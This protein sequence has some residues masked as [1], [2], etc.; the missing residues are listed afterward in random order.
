MKKAF[1][2]IE[3]VFV[4]VVIGVL[5]AVILPNTKT[6]PVQ[7]AAI[8]LVSHIRYTQHLAMVD[9]KFDATDGNWYKKRWQIVFVQHAEASSVP[10]YTIFSDTSNG[11]TGDANE[12]EIALNPVN[13]TQRMTGGHSGSV[14][15]DIRDSRFVGMRKLNL[16]LSYGITS[17]TMSNSCSVSGSRRIAFDHVGRPIRGSL[18]AAGGGGNA[19]SYENNN[20]IQADCIIT[21]TDGIES[22]LIR[23]TRETGY[24]CVLNATATAC[25]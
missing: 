11:S 5:S 9:D 7:E 10:A 6:N 2:M 12:L 13:V 21:L 8:Q 17:I 18:G 14:K 16:G 4:I 22:T 19:Q 3:L 25:I 24:T 15:L 23:V 1:T 20:L